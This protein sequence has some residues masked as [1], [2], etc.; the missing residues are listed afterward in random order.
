MSLA[1]A[2]IPETPEIRPCQKFEGH[3]HWVTD[4]IHLPREQQI[5]TSSLGSLRV[6][7]LQSGKQI[8]NDWGDGGMTIALSPDGQKVVS[9]GPNGGLKL[10]DTNTSE[11]IAEWTGHTTYVTSV[12]WSQDGGRV[13]SGSNDGTARVWDMKSGQTVLAIETGLSEVEAAIYS[14]DTAMIATGGGSKDLKEFI[15]IWDAKTGKLIANLKGHTGIV[16]C[17]AWTADGSRVYAHQIDG[18]AQA[19]ASLCGHRHRRHVS[20]SVGEDG[21]PRR[22]VDKAS[23]RARGDGGG[24]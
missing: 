2:G 10:W 14:P 8:G 12:C 16:Y 15:T 23:R 1:A 4:V 24:G 13:T 20:T 3:T 17:L 22:R 18:P 9:G 5:M 11:V 19:Y 21:D 6:W 7:N